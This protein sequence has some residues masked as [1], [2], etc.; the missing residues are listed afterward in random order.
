MLKRFDDEIIHVLAWKLN[1]ACFERVASSS[2]PD[3]LYLM[4][5]DS[6]TASMRYVFER[7]SSTLLFPSTVSRGKKRI[8]QSVE[9]FLSMYDLV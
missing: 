9:Q 8:F 4:S 1:V 2:N 5:L 3:S 7:L 6:L